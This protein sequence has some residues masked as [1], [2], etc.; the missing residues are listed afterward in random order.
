MNKNETGI[1][2]RGNRAAHNRDLLAFNIYAVLRDVD[3]HFPIVV[4]HQ[5]YALERKVGQLTYEVDWLKKNLS[6]FVYAHCCTIW[7]VGR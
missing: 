2:S 1:G 3:F 6:L 5:G 7:L 4:L